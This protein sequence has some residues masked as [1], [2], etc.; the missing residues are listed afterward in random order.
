[1]SELNINSTLFGGFSKRD[2]VAYVE[3][4]SVRLRAEEDG[5]RRA[6]E[7]LTAREVEL[8]ESQKAAAAATRAATELYSR[9][10]VM[11]AE[12]EKTSAVR[13]EL[14]QNLIEAE[15]HIEYL[16]KTLPAA[17]LSVQNEL[18]AL[19]TQIDKED[20][21][22]RSAVYGSTQTGASPGSEY[23][24]QKLAGSFDNVFALQKQ[25]AERLDYLI[26]IISADGGSFS[27]PQ[28]AEVAAPACPAAAPVLVQPAPAVQNV[29]RETPPVAVPNQNVS[30]ETFFRPTPAENAPLSAP[31]NAGAVELVETATTVPATAMG[32]SS[33]G[34]IAGLLREFGFAPESAAQEAAPAYT[35]QTAFAQPQNV[36]VQQAVTLPIQ[37]QA[38]EYA[39]ATP[40]AQSADAAVI[41]PRPISADDAQGREV[42]RPRS[43]SCAI[44]SEYI[45]KT[46]PRGEE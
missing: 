18:A 10:Q 34:D 6:S 41:T 2:V 38:A 29:S 23:W 25:L 17:A 9:G 14:K 36:P 7:E 22:L 24:P 21:L 45:R 46:E 30:R 27:A 3:A 19:R 4:L 37:P 13:D 12:L 16:Q 33:P 15:D 26:S 8:A 43:L 42:R 28:V 31:V 40:P 20:F 1:M 5:R 32:A 39:A 35:P 11:A 44:N